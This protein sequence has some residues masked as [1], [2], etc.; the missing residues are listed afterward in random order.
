MHSRVVATIKRYAQQKDPD[1]YL[2]TSE[3]LD[4]ISAKLF[5]WSYHIIQAR[6]FGRRLPWT[7]LVPLADCFNHANLPVRYALDTV[8]DGS[9]GGA[10]VRLHGDRSTVPRTRQFGRRWPPG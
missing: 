7:S 4:G 8:G 2:D 6:A 3:A 5:V 9:V 10:K 1:S